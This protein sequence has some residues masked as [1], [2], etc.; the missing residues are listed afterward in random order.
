MELEVRHI[1]LHFEIGIAV[2]SFFMK[3]IFFFFFQYIISVHIFF[4]GLQVHPHAL[5]ENSI[6]A[7]QD[8][9]L[10]SYILLE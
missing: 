5:L 4:C 7:M 1:S 2:I 3:D 10:F 8:M 6:V 9:L